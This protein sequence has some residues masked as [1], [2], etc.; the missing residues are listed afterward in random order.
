MVSWVAIDRVVER[1]RASNPAYR[2]KTAAR[3]L[4]SDARHLTDEELLA[5]LRSFGVEMDL[6]SLGRLCDDSLS[7]EE[8]AGP[9]IE[10]YVSGSKRKGFE[11]DWIWICL[12]ALW[13]RW[14]PDKPSF[15]TL[16]DKMQAGYELRDSG[17]AAATCRIWL[18]GWKDV[19][20]IFDKAG[21]ESV[22]E[23][24]S[25]FMGTEAIFNWIQD[26]QDE[27]LNAGL[28]NRRFLTERVAVCEEGLKRFEA[29]GDLTTQNRRRALAESYF[30]M[31]ETRGA[32]KLFQEWLKADPRWG[33]GWI[34]WSDCYR[35]TRT[36]HLDMNRAEEL[37]LKGLSIPEVM[38]RKYLIDRLAD[39]YED[40]G[41][42][43]EAAEIERHADSIRQTHVDL[44]SCLIQHK[45]MMTFGAEGLPISELPK[46]ADGLR[47]LVSGSAVGGRKV[48]R[49]ERCPCGS[50]KKFKKCC[51]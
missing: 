28:E 24:D 40:Q 16:D 46:A 3:P 44:D 10:Q 22:G 17:D 39:L 42:I 8:I 45:T 47:K 20:H 6:P 41:R 19:L 37:L 5:R 18:S 38:D 9:L 2:Q 32:D 49:N 25:L 7:A 27:L 33:W 12:T 13:E 23:F 35:F 30:E 21:I 11:S 43:E 26:L 1:E 4:R 15:E 36:E 50:G 31:G 14:F 34:G 51:G 48:G 29:E